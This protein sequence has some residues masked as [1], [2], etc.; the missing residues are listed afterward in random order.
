MSYPLGTPLPP[1]EF[2]V[3]VS[4]P[5]WQHVVG[6][7]E[8]DAEIIRHFRSGYPRFFL[9]PAIDA[10]FRA[11]EQA[12]GRNGER[13]V[14]FPRVEHAQRCVSWLAK[15]E[16]SARVES[17]TDAALGAC[18]F[19]PEAYDVAR[20]CWRF[21][22]ETISQR[23]ALAA[24]GKGDGVTLE[25]GSQAS[26]TLRDRIADL[27]AQQRQDVFLFPSGMAATFAVHRMITELFPGQRTVQLGFPYVDVLKVQ[28]HFGT[29][30]EFIAR[31]DE[32]DAAR[33]TDEPFAALFTELPMNPL[34]QCADFARVRA[35]CPTLPIVIDDTL[36]T[37]VHADA[38][39]VADAV[40]TSLTKSFS[41]AGDVL[42]GSV[43]L[44]R[45]SPHYTAFS[46]WMT[47]NHE[48]GLF[49][50]DAV[51]LEQNSRDFVSRMKRVSGSS[52]ALAQHLAA[53]PA[54]AR[55]WH[56]AF[57]GG[58]GYAMVQR[59]ADAHGCL[60]SF[61]LKDTSRTPAMYD[62]L[63]V[64]KGPSLGTNFTLVCPYTLLAHYDELEWA[65]SCGVSR[66]LIRVS[67]G[68]EPIDEIIAAFDAALMA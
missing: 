6:Y 8:G 23:Q 14:V 44:N 58:P 9:P 13:A 57:E 30:V 33:L 18:L 5:L 50:S 35:A 68:L 34:L 1:N 61:V 19:A 4:L 29:G 45:A 27:T 42:A 54:V 38:M 67:V 25:Q 12:L 11:A 26:L 3:S 2:G 31:L 32:L 40:T 7:E 41:G 66:W 64:C 55:V 24:L 28:Q 63:K 17:F 16:H 56:S 49:A 62:A 10:A 46:A 47:A 20:K 37:C 51:V 15:H 22:G 65:E 48:G 59:E 39:R 53:H 36:A 43:V 52:L 60:L 21:A